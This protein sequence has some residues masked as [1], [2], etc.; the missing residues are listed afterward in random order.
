MCVCADMR[1]CIYIFVYLCMFVY[2]IKILLEFQ[3]MLFIDC[4]D[5]DMY[6]M[7]VYNKIVLS[8]YV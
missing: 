7:H 4:V 8:L 2:I 3:H 1:V 6:Y 5:M